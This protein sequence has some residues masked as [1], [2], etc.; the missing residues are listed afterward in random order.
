MFKLVK[1]LILI[2]CVSM[3]CSFTFAE[4]PAMLSAGISINEQVPADLFGTWRVV[5]K[6]SATDSPVTFKKMGIDLWNLS[7]TGDV[8]NLCNPM[9]GASASVNVEYV[10]GNTIRFTK[11]GNYDNQLLT[12]TVEITLSGNKFTGVNYLSLK[13]YSSTDNS[14]IK[15]K[16]A[17][18]DLQGNKISGTSIL[19]R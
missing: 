18:Y 5:S 2:I 7:K 4:E 9:T 8:I 11:E 6:L 3:G 19:E 16:T 17:A 1:L 15:E 13:T 12:D 10:K 14:L